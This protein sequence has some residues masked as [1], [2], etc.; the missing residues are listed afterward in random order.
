MP[1]TLKDQWKPYAHLIPF[2]TVTERIKFPKSCLAEDVRFLLP[3]VSLGKD[4]PVVQNLV[5]ITGR[6]ICEVRPGHD[7]QDFDVALLASIANYRV[8]ISEQEVTQEE[9]VSEKDAVTERRVTK[10]TY[11]T[12]TILFRHDFDM[13]TE[14]TFVGEGRDAWI[15]HVLTA[16]PIDLLNKSRDE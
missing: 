12:A 11:G 2:E 4:G 5:L 9:P 1:D 15:Q 10:I 16:C 6:Y 7:R 14:L 3:S 8:S 13:A